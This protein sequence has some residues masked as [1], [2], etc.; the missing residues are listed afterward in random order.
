MIENEDLE[1]E[2]EETDTKE[3]CPPEA[4]KAEEKKPESG[5]EKRAKLAALEKKLAEAEA[6]LKEKDDKYLRMLA[7][8]DNFKRRSAKEKEGIYSDAYAD[9]IKQ[10]LT[11]LDNLDRASKCEDAKALADGLQMTVKGFAETLEKMGVEEIRAEG[12]TFDPNYH[13]AVMHIDDEAYG[14][15]T[16]AAVH[17]KGYKKGDKIIRF[18]VVTVAN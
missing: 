4:E 9:A 7:E 3:E 17:Q 11:V 8:Y 10:L 2:K 13:Y 5:K 18:A 1:V 15:N 14:E 16:V 12:E 6:A